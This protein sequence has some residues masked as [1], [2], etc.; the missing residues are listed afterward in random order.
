MV[1]GME[2][3]QKH[4]VGE[5]PCVRTGW[6]AAERA[7]K[8]LKAPIQHLIYNAAADCRMNFS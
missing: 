3:A 7:H 1:T 5:S 2:P 8:R 6:H 4:D